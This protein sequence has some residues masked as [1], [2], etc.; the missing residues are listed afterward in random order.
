ML[1]WQPPPKE[2]FHSLAALVRW[3]DR[4]KR[5]ARLRKLLLCG[6]HVVLL[7]LVVS[8]IGYFFGWWGR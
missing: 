4:N 2:G 1:K 3:H 8:A 5:R 6:R 7:T